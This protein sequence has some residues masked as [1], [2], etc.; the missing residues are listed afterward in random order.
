VLHQA[1][2][3]ALDKSAA[4][5]SLWRKLASQEIELA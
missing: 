5:G 4:D 3:D 1:R 2:L